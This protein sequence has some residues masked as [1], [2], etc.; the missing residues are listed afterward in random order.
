MTSLGREL[1]FPEK[2]K[3]PRKV[4]DLVSAIGCGFNR[5]QKAPHILRSPLLRL[6]CVT[7]KEGQLY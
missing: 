4:V 2:E 7:T 1:Q 3:P 6:L 5:S